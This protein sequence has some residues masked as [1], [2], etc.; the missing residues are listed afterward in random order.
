MTEPDSDDVSESW[1]ESESES[2][3]VFI[4][5]SAFV[6]SVRCFFFCA[7]VHSSQPSRAWEVLVPGARPRFAAANCS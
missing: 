5:I 7:L 2:E 3:S 6:G 4:L 1:L